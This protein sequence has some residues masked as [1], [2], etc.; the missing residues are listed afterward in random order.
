MET[1]WDIYC[2]ISF[3]VK[4]INNFSVFFTRHFTFV[5]LLFLSVLH[6]KTF[7]FYL[8]IVFDEKIKIPIFPFK[9]FFQKKKKKNFSTT[10]KP[11]P[12]KKINLKLYLNWGKTE[13]F[14]R[15]SW[16]K[17]HLDMRK[18]ATMNFPTSYGERKYWNTDDDVCVGNF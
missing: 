13:K 7:K 15:L 3:G 8:F 14:V 6:N 4:K 18:Y 1:C 11:K 12:K 10:T 9:I 2:I 16:W 17:Y 5:S